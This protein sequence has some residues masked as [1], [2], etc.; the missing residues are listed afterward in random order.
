MKPASIL[1]GALAMLV[2]GGLALASPPGQ[3]VTYETPEGAVTY[4]ADLHASKGAKCNDCHPKVFPMKA[5]EMPFTMAAMQ[6][7]QACGACHDGTK[8]FG[9][10][11]EA[12]CSNCHKK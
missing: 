3:S 4:D 9:V 7:G 2:C 12:A 5:A 6:E 10:A 1:L 11:D 8:A